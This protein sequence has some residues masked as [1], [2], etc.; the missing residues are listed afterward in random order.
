M[1]MMQRIRVLVS[2]IE[3]VLVAVCG[4]CGNW[5]TPSLHCAPNTVTRGGS[6]QRLVVC[7]YVWAYLWAYQYE[8]MYGHIYGHIYGLYI[9][10]YAH[11]CGHI[12]VYVWARRG[13]AVQNVG[14]WVEVGCEE[15]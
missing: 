6:K 4:A 5:T 3:L 9:Y 12:Y 8:H 1:Q 10:I 11:I 14:Y 7:A 2:V 13:S 15:V